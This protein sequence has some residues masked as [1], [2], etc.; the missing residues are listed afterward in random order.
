[1][2]R[3]FGGGSSSLK[4]PMPAAPSLDTG[5]W[6]AVFTEYMDPAES[7][8][9]DHIANLLNDLITAVDP[10]YSLDADS[11]ENPGGVWSST[12]PLSLIV[13]SAA[14]LVQLTYRHPYRA[15]RLCS[16]R[17]N[18]R[19]SS[20]KPLQSLMQLAWKCECQVYNYFTKENWDTGM[21][22]MG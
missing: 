3:A 20:L 1:M 14:R 10:S 22:N 16:T 12:P 5:K 7:D 21:V 13:V 8:E 19:A 15:C 17:S 4:A 11:C 2:R 18:N 6:H 9:K